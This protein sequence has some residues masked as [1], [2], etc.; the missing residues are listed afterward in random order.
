[1][2]TSAEI[3]PCVKQTAERAKGEASCDEKRGATWG[4]EIIIPAFCYYKIAP[5][6]PLE[7]QH[8]V[9]PLCQLGLPLL[10]CFILPA[11]QSARVYA[12]FARCLGSIN[13][14]G[15]VGVDPVQIMTGPITDAH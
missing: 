1:M 6:C 7:P 3:F 15:G 2:A 14:A 5:V 11:P 4:E 8:L 9:L 12:H 13:N 10:F